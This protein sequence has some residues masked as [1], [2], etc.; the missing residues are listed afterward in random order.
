MNL[1]LNAS[2]LRIVEFDRGHLLALAV[3]GSGKTAALKSRF[4]YL[5]RNRGCDPREIFCLTFT[6]AAAYEMTRRV[7]DEL[8]LDERDLRRQIGTY[9]RLGMRIIRNEMGEDLS[10]KGF[11][12]KPGRQKRM[13]E[14]I[15]R[16]GFTY[17]DLKDYVSLSKRALVSPKAALLGAVPGGYRETALAE[18]FQEYEDKLRQDGVLDFDSM[19]YDAY[20]LLE[21]R[22][23]VASRYSREIKHMVVDEFQDTSIAQQRLSVLL[24]KH[25]ESFVA[26]GDAC[27]SIYGFA[28]A[29]YEVIS[30]FGETFPDYKTVLMSKNYRSTKRIID[31]CKLAAST[32]GGETEK[33][34]RAM[35]TDNEHGEPVE[36]RLFSDEAAE[37][38]W[39]FKTVEEF[40]SSKRVSL[41]DVGVL[42]RTNRQIRLG[43][44][45]CRTRG[46]AYVTPGCGFYGRMEI[47][48]A[49]SLLKMVENPNS[50]DLV[51]CRCHDG[52]CGHCKEGKVSQWIGAR[53]ARS[54]LPC[55]RYVVPRAVEKVLEKSPDSPFEACA[56]FQYENAGIQ[57]AVRNFSFFFL[58]L[59]Q[60]CGNRPLVEQLETIYGETEFYKWLSS[61][62][63]LDEGD[64]DRIKNAKELISAVSRFKDRASFLRYV[65]SVQDAPRRRDSRSRNSI[66]L[67]TIHRAKGAEW[68]VV[69]VCGNT[70]DLLPGARG[71]K[72]EEKRVLYVA[73]TRARKRL[74]L[75]G[76]G[77]P[78]D[79]LRSM[80][81]G[82]VGA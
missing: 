15:L 56:D 19:I 39:V 21:S 1:Q 49:V 60:R 4:V 76:F 48:M 32:M 2:Q 45:H 26:V 62:K 22:P 47:K 73:V 69:F 64:N 28:G 16:P 31:V 68:R 78:S 29:N 59:S 55:A 44:D 7:A 42:Y 13:I 75:S 38:E 10:P 67:S 14:N 79:F 35:N 54:G 27:Q 70:K 66:T 24:S 36:W 74:F 6:N 3:P 46:W 81:P 82:E 8:N 12:V 33:L 65:D 57:R 77:E 18:M 63:E 61:N 37:A 17:S 34:L 20:M 25:S 9:H 51:R 53:I 40:L 11:V 80:L 43:E 58:N 30:S 41:R 52:R 72:E 23:D 50:R 71:D 5:V